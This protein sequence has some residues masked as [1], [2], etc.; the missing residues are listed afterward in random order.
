MG[1]IT[2]IRKQTENRFVNLYELST[3]RK[4][5]SAGRYF[6]ASRAE[7]CDDLKIRTRRNDPDGVVMFML[8]GKAR[9]RVVLIRQYRYAIDDWIYELP[10]GLVEKGEDFREAAVREAKEETGLVFTPAETD[11]S[12][13]R[14]F[15]M[16]VGLTDES[17]CIVYG[18]ADGEPTDRYLEANE[19]IEVVLA[20]RDE[21]RR[22]LRE[23]NVAMTCA[24]PLISFLAGA[25][26]VTQTTADPRGTGADSDAAEDAEPA[27]GALPSGARY[28]IGLDVGGTGIKA[29]LVTESGELLDRKYR[30]IRADGPEFEA[31]LLDEMA[32]LCDSL[33]GER[34]LKRG[35]LA[36]VGIGVPGPV[37][38][39]NGLFLY[40][41]NLPVKDLPL[42]ERFSERYGVPC[43]LG[44][45]A[46]CAALGEYRAGAG[47]QSGSLVLI[48]I[49]TGIGTGI[50]L[51]GKLW[52]GFNGAAGEGG[53]M[54]LREGGRRCGC[55]REGCFEAYASATALIRGTREMMADHPESLLWKQ[56]GSPDAVD[57]ETAFAA[58]K[59]GDPW[60]QEVIDRY[61][62][63]LAEGIRSV[64]HLLA[65]ECVCLG[66]GISGAD[67][68]QLL[69]PLREKLADDPLT[70][71]CPDRTR[72]VTAELGNDAGMIGAAMLFLQDTAR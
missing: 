27:G 4:N 57:G 9:D 40:A 29:G 54:I 52:T 8:Y 48:T 10:A 36:G 28:Y 71:R 69:L 47:K 41:P 23:E 51:D 19:E 12:Y 50:V 46:N 30:P 22:I 20:D 60:A 68:K 32:K 14:P 18:C 65:P 39:R 37:D 2:G 31:Y 56:A 1:T 45:D 59:A 34:G 21:I 63:S 43:R 33:L 6:V 62:G 66:G 67:P 15:Y 64:I 55:G 16:T 61:I 44:N 70:E 42:A 24:L 53:H 49:G 5:G 7:C 58:A 11:P 38:D 72:I 26:P 13:E 17:C 25:D 3:I 35:D